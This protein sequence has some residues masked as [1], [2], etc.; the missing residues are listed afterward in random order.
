LHKK[1]ELIVPVM[2][3]EV[4]YIYNKCVE[5]GICSLNMSTACAVV[6]NLL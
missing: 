2:C 6:N 1:D 5:R 4:F 3:D